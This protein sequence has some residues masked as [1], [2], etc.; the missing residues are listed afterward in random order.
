MPLRVIHTLFPSER[1]APRSRSPRPGRVVPLSAV[2][3]GRAHAKVW[4][5]GIVVEPCG[6]GT[7]ADVAK[8]AALLLLVDTVAL[9][10][11][12]RV[13]VDV[14]AGP[15]ANRLLVAVTSADASDSTP[16]SSTAVTT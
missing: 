8:Q 10:A 4:A 11:G 2:S 12:H 5:D 7:L 3:A 6:R 16:S 14:V 1:D 13:P 15:L 9:G